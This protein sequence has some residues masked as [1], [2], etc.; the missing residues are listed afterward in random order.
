MCISPALPCLCLGLFS[1][2]SRGRV[3]DFF[4]AS[5]RQEFKTEAKMDRVGAFRPSEK[6]LGTTAR[7][8]RKP[9]RGG[10]LWGGGAAPKFKFWYK[11]AHF[12]DGSRAS[13]GFFQNF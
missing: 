2:F 12:S 3:P 13:A 10:L 9:A 1:W 11:F 6:L 4:S 8:P 7:P 5:D